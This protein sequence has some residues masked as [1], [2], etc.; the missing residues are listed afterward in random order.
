M[1]HWTQLGHY[2]GG[3]LTVLT[4]VVYP[5]VSVLFVTL[6]LLYEMGQTW[7]KDDWFDEETREFLVGMGIGMTGVLVL[8]VL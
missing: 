6:F 4:A 8:T 3:L 2:L 1:S 5:I 7:Q